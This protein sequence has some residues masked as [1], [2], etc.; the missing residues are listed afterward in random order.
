[1][2]QTE[3][4]NRLDEIERIDPD[5]TSDV[6]TYAI[7][8]VLGSTPEGLHLLI[9]RYAASPCANIVTFLAL[10]FS[11]KSNRASRRG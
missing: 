11:V 2:N 8:E 3:A 10:L 6:G 7:M 9:D 4:L 5:P 1:M